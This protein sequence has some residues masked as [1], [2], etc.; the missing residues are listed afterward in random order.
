M[1]DRPRGLF[2][3]ASYPK[4][5]NTWVRL[6]LNA[7]YT[8]VCNINLKFFANASDV[9]PAQYHAVAHTDL[10]ELPRGVS[11]LLPPRSAAEYGSFKR[12]ATECA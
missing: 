9:K 4:S 1:I 12:A 2:W 3:L 5:G 7:Y 6:F 10:K 8:G 11:L